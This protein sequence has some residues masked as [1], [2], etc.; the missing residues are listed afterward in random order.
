MSQRKSLSDNK[1]GKFARLGRLAGTRGVQRAITET[2]ESRKLMTVTVNSA[3]PVQQVVQGT[4]TA[5]VDVSKL[6][7]TNA[8]ANRV[9]AL[10]IQ[11][12]SGTSAVT[13]NLNVGLYDQPYATRTA[14][15][16]TTNNFLSY[17]GKG[18]FTNSVFHRSLNFQDNS[19]PAQF[20]QGGGFTTN[21]NGSLSS[22]AD[23]NPINL[24]FDNSRSN[25]AGTIS[26]ARTSDPNSATAGFFFN[27]QD[28]SAIF[29]QPG[30]QYAVFGQVLG[31]G[32]QSLTDISSLKR[33]DA[34]VPFTGTT[35]QTFEGFP[36]VG[37]PNGT[38]PAPSNYLVL[39]TATVVKPSTYVTYQVSSSNPG[40]V[41]VR[42]SDSGSITFNA[43]K[44][45]TGSATITVIGTDLSGA[46]NQATF[47]AKVVSGGTLGV[48]LNDVVVTKGQAAVNVGNAALT[49][50]LTA[51]LVLM[52]TGLN[53]LTV[54]GIDF[55]AGYSLKGSA[56]TTILA[57]STFTVQVAVDTSKLGTQAGRIVIHT[58]DGANPDFSVALTAN[59]HSTIQV[60]V[61]GNE[62]AAVNA[63]TVQLG[64]LSAGSTTTAKV[65]LVNSGTSALTISSIDLPAGY[66]LVETL[67]ATIS[68]GGFVQFTVAVD[69]SVGGTKKGNIVV[70]STDALTPAFT[71]PV[72][73]TVFTSLVLDNKTVKT[74]VFTEADGTQGTLSLVGPGKLSAQIV[75]ENLSAKTVKGVLTILQPG[76]SLQGL[77]LTGTNSKSNL[78]LTSKG[79]DKQIGL[80]DI[81]V[82][83]TKSSVGTLNLSPAVLSG[84]ANIQ[85]SIAGLSVAGISGGNLSVGSSKVGGKPR[86][87]LDL[88][89]LRQASVHVLTNGITAVTA[90]GLDSSDLVGRVGL[91]SVTVSGTVLNSQI[92][93]GSFISALTARSLD[94][95]KVLAGTKGAGVDGMGLAPTTQAELGKGSIGSVTLRGKSSTF[96]GSVIAAAKLGN[97]A[98]GSVVPPSKALP[99]AV[100]SSVIGNLITT[101]SGKVGS[102]SFSLSAINDQKTLKAALK[103]AKVTLPST[104][105]VT[106]Y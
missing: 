37:Y 27:T 9:V 12:G 98:L 40:L 6:F 96:S 56:P 22:I 103:S 65:Q 30:N 64:T 13:Y 70:H 94:G 5:S 48:K 76:A 93:A 18:S 10:T 72:T 58:N 43:A 33:I 97:L 14:A 67:P 34:S 45:Q 20:L 46:T 25:T 88:G 4:T 104:L 66:T 69:T 89:S 53:D 41:G 7:S 91:S 74:I 31:N 52:S 35:P 19:K 60:S 11:G 38:T 57:G 95:S 39:K 36:V 86:M 2:L 54:S 99:A 62:I 77:T 49:A 44:G 68:V 85:G 26:M 15:T 63:P 32:L 23:D 28:N 55:P 51:S 105:T 73:A 90:S 59:V 1:L 75:G 79:K 83:G 3:I 87:Q 29:D 42:L 101:F 78:T 24:E 61:N 16:V 106:V 84:T 8:T 92:E 50:P 47:Q 71:V 81:T 21:G 80:G 82:S 100:A 17:V 102:K